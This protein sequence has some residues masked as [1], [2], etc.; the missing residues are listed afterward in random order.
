VSDAPAPPGEPDATPASSASATAAQR[1]RRRGSLGSL[2]RL[3]PFLTPYLGQM[4]VVILVTL[5]FAG[6]D[7]YRATLAKPLLNKVFMRGGEVQDQVKDDLRGDE[8]KGIPAAVAAASQQESAIARITSARVAEIA[9]SP[10]LLGAAD[11]VPAGAPDAALLDRSGRTLR[12]IA[13]DLPPVPA[14]AEREWNL[15][16]RGVELQLRARALALSQPDAAAL[17]SLQARELARQASFELAW[18]T[19]TYVILV[20]LGLAVSLSVTSYY[21]LYLSRALVAQVF[22]D[23]QNETARH[24]LTLS[25]RFFERERR[26]DILG[27]LTADLGHTANLFTTLVDIVIRGLHLLVLVVWALTISPEL[28]GVLLVLGATVLLPLRVLGRK[29]RRS[30]KRRQQVTGESIEVMQQV[31]GGIREVKALDR[32]EHEA[33][34]F[35]DVSREGL[36]ALVRGLKGRAASKAWMQ[37]FN[38]IAI[39]VLFIVGSWLVV[40]RLWGIDVGTFAA[41]LGLVL[42]M[43]HPAKILGESY[44]TLMD[45]LPAL[46]RVFHLFD[47]RPEVTEPDEP[48]PF[49]GLKESVELRGVGF[50]YD[51]E[52]E[53]LSD[54]DLSAPAGSMTALVGTTGSGKSTLV[55]LIARYADPTR[56][57]V[58]LDGTPLPQLALRDVLDRLAV[59]PQENFLFNDT[60]RENIRYGR[61]DA[62]DEEVE[63][64]ARQAEIHDEIVGL[65]EGYDYVAGERGGRL[66]GGQVQRIAIAR[67]ILKDPEILILDEA[68]SAL[69]TRTEAR[70]QQALAA[71]AQGATSFWIAHRLS[72]VQRADQILVLSQGKVVERGTHDELLEK[73]EVYARLVAEQLEDC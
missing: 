14:E 21:M 40:M 19:L 31:L 35:R 24:L 46:E 48:Q 71:L 12:E 18:R 52:N 13:D 42:L 53:V 51:G 73:G 7:A 45:A 63:E 17:L 62:S 16:A 34:R 22:V 5:A 57:E 20:A 30:A 49:A 3:R 23:L 58:L 25:V 4:L 56:G 54:V 65:P 60:V 33:Q 38:D 15:I 36:R 32:E 27:R 66:S 55:D 8:V 59:V 28:A 72:T 39:P 6:S 11:P 10:Q 29:I 41:F 47:Q 43:Y 44:N 50:S 2:W 67:A 37:L 61:L 1:K 68:T 70:V 64:A 26:G 69:D 9:A